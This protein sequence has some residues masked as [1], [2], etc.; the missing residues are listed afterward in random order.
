[1][2]ITSS[3][4]GRGSFAKALA[5][6]PFNSVVSIINDCNELGT[7]VFKIRLKCP[8]LNSIEL[9]KFSF[10]IFFDSTVNKFSNSANLSMCW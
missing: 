8:L 6:N 4:F 1:M 2:G 3:I 5:R 7:N 9:S 10:L